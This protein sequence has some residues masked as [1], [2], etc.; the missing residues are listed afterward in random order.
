MERVHLNLEI[1]I[2]GDYGAA[3]AM[4]TLSVLIG[5][6]N[7]V[8]MFFLILW[9]MVFFGLN[10]AIIQRVGIR[11]AGGS[12]WIHTFGSFFGL[13][14]SFFFQPTRSE[15]SGN[16]KSSYHSEVTAALGCLFLFV[17]WPSFNSA[18]LTGIEQERAIISTVL[19][20]L[21]SCMGALSVS[22]LIF[23][24]I[25]MEMLLHGSLS[26]GV[27]IGICANIVDEPWK[28]MII[29]LFAGIISSI[30]VQRINP[31]L[32]Y[33]M[34]VQDTSAALSVFGI[35]GILGAI[36]SAIIIAGISDQRFS[37]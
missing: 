23:G 33:Y 4:I 28:A 34:N 24:K 26:G 14:A 11:D 15:I 35:P 16:W 21:S 3:A 31:F 32:S 27:A 18:L 29:G 36:S 10:L 12:V 5:K 1:L 13:G 19:A 7:L 8:Q 37:E 20:I 22:R 25:E 17:Y 9:E 2:M 30:G 6:C